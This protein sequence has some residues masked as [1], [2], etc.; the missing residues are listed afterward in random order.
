MST[1]RWIANVAMLC[2]A[3]FRSVAAATAAAL[4]GNPVDSDPAFF[5]REV[6]LK[7]S[8]DVTYYLAHSRIREKVLI[9]LPA[10]PVQFPGA[11]YILTRH[12]DYPDN[13]YLTVR[14]WLDSLGLEFKDE[15]IEDAE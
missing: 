5:S 13:N 7:G 10:L 15:D 9:A 3:Q 12:D 1:N 8:S 2:P 4:S 14:E 11:L 6:G